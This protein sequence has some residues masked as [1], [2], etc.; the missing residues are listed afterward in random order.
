[1]RATILRRIEAVERVAPPDRALRT[2]F[3]LAGTDEARFL[4]DMEAR[5]PGA[6]LCVIEALPSDLADD[7]SAAHALVTGL[8]GRRTGETPRAKV[9]TR[10]DPETAR[11][12]AFTAARARREALQ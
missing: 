1:M 7:A 4:A 11:R 3:M 5:H 9:R 6:D 12:L 2:V 10:I 8:A